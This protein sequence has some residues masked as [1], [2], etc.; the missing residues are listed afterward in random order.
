MIYIVSQF[1]NNF[2]LFLSFYLFYFV[3]FSQG[4]VGEGGE[5]RE[6]GFCCS[7]MSEAELVSEIVYIY[8]RGRRILCSYSP[9][10]I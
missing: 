6:E 4:R 7:F 1:N 2:S 5:G 10:L 3:L 8:V 9:A